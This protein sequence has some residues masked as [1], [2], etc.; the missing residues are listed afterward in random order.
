MLVLWRTK[1]KYVLL[2]VLLLNLG[3][4]LSGCALSPQQVSLMPSVTVDSQPY[5]A[6]RAATVSVLDDRNDEVLGTRGGVYGD[7]SLITMTKGMV[8]PVALASEKILSQL[9]FDV[10]RPG[11][12]NAGFGTNDVV[13]GESPIKFTVVIANLNYSSPN[14]VFANSVNGEV[15][16]KLNVEK[17]GEEFNSRFKTKNSERFFSVPDDKVN[18]VLINKLFSE[19]LAKLFEDPSLAHFLQ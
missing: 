2:F 5:G 13:D 16:L 3:S 8:E 17:N 11:A 14:K 9:G 12:S 10:S 19:T 15:E 7:T 1:M 18:M 6:G 4:A